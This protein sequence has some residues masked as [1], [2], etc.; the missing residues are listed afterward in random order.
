MNDTSPEKRGPQP[1]TLDELRSRPTVT[2]PQAG[3]V[4]GLG[5]DA[6]YECARRGDIPT[7]RL[8]RRVVVPTPRLL[9][10]LGVE[11]PTIEPTRRLDLQGHYAGPLGAVPDER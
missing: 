6:A 9:A 2:V 8:G 5:K 1:L 10:M 7:I 3:M 4:L 11:V